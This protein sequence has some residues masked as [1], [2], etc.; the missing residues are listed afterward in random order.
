MGSLFFNLGLILGCYSVVQRLDGFGWV[1]LNSN[2][3]RKGGAGWARGPKGGGGGEDT[4]H[5]DKEWNCPVD[6]RVYVLH[7]YNSIH[8]MIFPLSSMNEKKN[9]SHILR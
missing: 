9:L 8:L 1:N 5:L 6:V 3:K 4:V 7:P 2:K